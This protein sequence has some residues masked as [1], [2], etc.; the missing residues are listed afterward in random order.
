MLMAVYSPVLCIRNEQAKRV[1][2]GAMQGYLLLC[3]P[4]D[5]QGDGR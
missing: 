2:R 1:I 3:N 5:P 4:E